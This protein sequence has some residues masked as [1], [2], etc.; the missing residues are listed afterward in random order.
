MMGVRR[1]LNRETRGY[2]ISAWY[3]F[4]G[5]A[6]L[7]ALS[8]FFDDRG[9]EV[10]WF[11]LGAHALAS[12]L[13]GFLTGQL[14][15]APE[16]AL[17]SEAQGARYSAAL[18]NERAIGLFSAGILFYLTGLGEILDKLNSGDGFDGDAFK[19]ASACDSVLQWFLHPIGMSSCDLLTKDLEALKKIPNAPELV[20]LLAIILCAFGIAAALAARLLPRLSQRSESESPTWTVKS[21]AY[22]GGVY[23]ALHWLIQ[24]NWVVV[25]DRNEAD[26]FI[27]LVL[28]L[29]GATYLFIGFDRAG[30]SLSETTQRRGGWLKLGTLLSAV[31]VMCLAALV[32]GYFCGCLSDTL[33][34]ALAVTGLAALVA[35]LVLM[36]YLRW[37]LLAAAVAAVAGLVVFRCHL[38]G[39]IRVLLED[40]KCCE[41]S[42]PPLPCPE[43]ST[44]CT[45]ST[46]CPR[47]DTNM[48]AT[49]C[50]AGMVLTRQGTCAC[51]ENTTKAGCTCV[52]DKPCAATITF[53][54]ATATPRDSAQIAEAIAAFRAPHCQSKVIVVT[55]HGDGGDGYQDCELSKRRATVVAERLR[56]ALGESRTII[57]G[58]ANLICR[59]PPPPPCEDPC[60]PPEPPPCGDPCASPHEET[61]QGGRDRPNGWP[62]A[63]QTTRGG[64]V[65]I[66]GQ[67]PPPE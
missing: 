10:P 55:G 64:V 60:A 51:P 33:Q 52:P 45:S 63:P 49:G 22:L 53:N 2:F 29:A 58:N 46:P 19:G 3:I 57:D 21:F 11:S 7:V 44:G 9:F 13:T 23:F 41:C 4:I 32:A 54:P 61:P 66:T 62:E 24:S 26:A 1:N 12:L 17:D 28:A 30:A 25:G 50:A 67:D 31:V 47:P 43:C 38:P 34:A 36:G 42:A 35:L 6:I 37:L 15:G 14:F 18:V 40:W 56:A 27:V 20:T 8:N 59:R 39:P 65:D 5:F 16:T 48:V